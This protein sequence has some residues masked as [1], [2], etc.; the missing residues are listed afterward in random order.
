MNGTRRLFIGWIAF[1]ALLLFWSPTIAAETFI[2]TPITL[3]T[4]DILPPALLQGSNYK[5]AETVHNDGV[6][7]TYRIDTDY[8]SFYAESTPELL[9]I[10]NDLNARAANAGSI[11]PRAALLAVGGNPFSGYRTGPEP[12]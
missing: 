7:N 3:K 6:I 2:P 11:L 9:L 4:A 8:G 5:L 10:I 12:S 1:T